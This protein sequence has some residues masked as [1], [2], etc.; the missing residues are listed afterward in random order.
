[1]DGVGL[2]QGLARRGGRCNT[3]VINSLAVSILAVNILAVNILAVLATARGFRRHGSRCNIFAVLLAGR[4]L[5][6]GGGRWRIIAVLAGGGGFP[7]RFGVKI[8]VV[9]NSIGWCNQAS[10]RLWRMLVS[11]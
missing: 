8:A 2:D 7:G 1:M 6:K 11:F 4:W 10:I 9:V 5:R 3:L